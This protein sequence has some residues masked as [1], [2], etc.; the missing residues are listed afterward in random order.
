[1]NVLSVVLSAAK[2]HDVKKNRHKIHNTGEG[3]VCLSA[4]KEPQHKTKSDIIRD[5]GKGTVCLLLKS[6]NIKK[7]QTFLYI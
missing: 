3:T 5:T 6:H 4:A 7:N 2:S 1:M